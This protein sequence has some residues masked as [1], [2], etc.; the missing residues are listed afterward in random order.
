[1]L[2][3]DP[4]LSGKLAAFEHQ[5]LLQ[6]LEEGRRAVRL[7]YV[8]SAARSAAGQSINSVRERLLPIAEIVKVVPIALKSS[9]DAASRL[10]FV[11]LLV[12]SASDEALTSAAGVESVIG[13][14][15]CAEGGLPRDRARPGPDCRR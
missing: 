15:R 1:M 2:D 6:A 5:Q 12:T 4:A 14:C 11:L 7:E 9:K 10:A 8:P 3:L 13:S